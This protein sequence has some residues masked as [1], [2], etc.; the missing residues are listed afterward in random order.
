MNSD[1][2][3]LKINKLSFIENLIAQ[4]RSAGINNI[5]IITNENLLDKIKDAFEEDEIQILINPNPEKGKFGSILLGIREVKLS[6]FCF[7][8]NIDNP[9]TDK[10]LIEEMCKAATKESYVVPVF[11]GRGG[12]PVLISKEIILELNGLTETGYNLR[13]VLS[14]YKKIMLNWH[15]RGILANINTIDDYREYFEHE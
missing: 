6:H 9:F 10:S 11:D 5:Y 4:Y 12:H 7:I 13:D 2:A 14:K 15:N 3:F 8:Q 1:K